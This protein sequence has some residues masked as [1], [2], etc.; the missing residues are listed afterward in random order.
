[1]KS[2]AYVNNNIQEATSTSQVQ[3]QAITESAVNPQHAKQLASQVSAAVELGAHRLIERLKAALVF[4]SPLDGSSSSSDQS[5]SMR[6]QQQQ[7]QS[8]F[9][10]AKME[11][12]VDV[13]SLCCSTAVIFGGLVPYVP[14]Y[15]K[16]KRSRNSDGFSTYGELQP[17]HYLD[18]AAVMLISALKTPSLLNSTPG[19][20]PQNYV[21]V[22][23]PL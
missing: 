2:G 21:L 12:F 18:R 7:Q 16:I 17:A 5:T 10:E 3:P 22:R 1:M 9:K 23:P 15:L 19:Q 11:S 14:Q 4:V 20:H 13:F 6:Q 8:W